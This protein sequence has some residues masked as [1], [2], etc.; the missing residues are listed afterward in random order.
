MTMPRTRSVVASVALAAATLSLAACSL[1]PLPG[2]AKQPAPVSTP[3]SSEPTVGQCWDA[4]YKNAG[5]WADWEGT[6]AT[7]CSATH[8]LYTYGVVKL[9]GL[10]PTDWATSATNPALSD[11]I[12][13][14]ASAACDAPYQTFLPDL[15][16]NQELVQSFFFV[17][18][19]AEWA[20]GARWVRCDVGQLDYGTPL[21]SEEFAP[22]PA[23]ISTLVTGV[24][25][26]PDQYRFCVTTSHSTAK[27]PLADS[28]AVVTD[29][30]DNPQWQL[31]THGDVAGNATAA[32]P[33]AKFL[34]QASTALC[35][36]GLNKGDVYV[37]Y[38]PS[39]DEWATGDREI[40]CWVA[41]KSAPGGGGPTSNA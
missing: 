11:A 36:A 26:D 29:C 20:K 10:L 16:W 38:P 14:K 18:T 6:S 32:Y 13:S 30:R 5:A 1:L 12:S 8:T 3:A 25:S 35:S 33:S 27:G 9:T 28:S 37:G 39:K 2:Q 31:T 22:L 4:T 17:P 21:A 19:R 40:Q 24:A 34:D 41:V 7:R 23:A 15:R